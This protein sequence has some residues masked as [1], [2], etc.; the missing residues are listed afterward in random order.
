V[1]S[2]A[3][4]TLEDSLPRKDT[5]PSYPTPMEV[6]EG[7]S[8]LEVA[9]AED[10]APEGGTGSYPTPEGV[11]GSDLA[12][13][14]VLA[15]IQPPRMFR[16]ALS[17]S[18]ASMDVQIESSPIRSEGVTIARASTALTGQVALEVGERDAGSLLSAGGAEV[19]VG[20]ALKIVHADLPSSSHAAASPALGL[21]LFLSNL[22]VS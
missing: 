3:S 7:P 19:T 1:V 13:W 20:S 22:E 11:V 21:P 9:A 17:L 15:I 16:H 6:A 18:N 14:V 12:L 2:R 8:A 5:D 10:P 4:S